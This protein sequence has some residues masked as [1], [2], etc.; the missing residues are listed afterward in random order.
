MQENTKL[1]TIISDHKS[2]PGKLLLSSGWNA[3]TSNTFTLLE[4][5]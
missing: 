2:Y 4:A 5:Q 1:R 3:F